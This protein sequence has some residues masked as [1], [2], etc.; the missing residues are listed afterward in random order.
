MVDFALQTHLPKEVL[1]VNRVRGFIL[2]ELQAIAEEV[3]QLADETTATFNEVRVTWEDEVRYAGG[4]AS[5]LVTTDNEIFGYLNDGT[6]VRWAIMNDPYSPKTAP[7]TWAAGEGQRTYNRQGYYTAIRG[8]RAMLQ[9]GIGPQPGIAGRNWTKQ[10]KDMM[11][12]DFAERLQEAV[13]RGL[14]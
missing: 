14:E 5:V 6:G 10:L 13:N 12:K 1:S 2:S 9:R 7:G 3:L 11:E 4:D 8:K